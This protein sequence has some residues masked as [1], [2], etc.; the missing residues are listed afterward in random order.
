MEN[1]KAYIVA[2][3]MGYGHQRAA[4]PLIKF[5]DTPEEWHLTQPIVISANNYPNIPKKDKKKWYQV[6]K[7]YEGISRLNGFPIFGKTIFHI[8]DYF[9]KIED[10][11]PRRDLSK[12]NFEAKQSHKMISKGLGKHLIETLN[13][14]PLPLICTFPIPALFAEAH[15]YKGEIYC[16]CT[17]TD[18]ARAWVALKPKESRITYLAPTIRAKERLMLYGV[19]PEKIIVTNF[20]IPDCSSLSILQRR[21]TKLDPLGI[22]REQ[23]KDLLSLYV[24]K[25]KATDLVNKPLTI[26]YAVGGAGAQWKTGVTIIKSLQEQIKNGEI[27]LNLVAGTSKKILRRFEKALKKMKLETYRDRGVSI[28]Y[29][30]EKFEYF[31]EFSKVLRDTDI[32][33]T[34]P[35]ELSFYAG[36]GLPIIMTP[37][38]GAQEEYNKTWLHMIGAGFEEYNPKYVNEWLPDWLKSSWLA[39]AAINGYLNAPKNAVDNIEKIISK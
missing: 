10:F 36:L 29:R 28:I 30:P 31:T 34:K 26:S 23:Y 18:I 5:A 37:P 19:R 15:G 12:P 33:W 4:F 39:E 2:V 35:S 16:L 25:E 14:K 20:P 7:L 32:L 9:Q 24:W 22:F 27:Q 13:K 11:Y 21:I 8:M 17:D 1:K 6:Q 3:D 38:L